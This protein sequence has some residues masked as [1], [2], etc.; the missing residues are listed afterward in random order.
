MA[1]LLLLQELLSD[2]ADPEPRTLVLVGVTGDGKSST[3]NT[4]CGRAAFATSDGLSSETAEPVPADYALSGEEPGAAAATRGL[5][6]V[7]DTVG[8]ADTSLPA[9][10]VAARFAP[11]LPGSGLTSDGAGRGGSTDGL[12]LGFGSELGL[13]AQAASTESAESEAAPNSVLARVTGTSPSA[14]R[15]CA[16]TSGTA[17]ASRRTPAP[18]P[19]RR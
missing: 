8:L 10:E 5:W 3:G 7:I 12:A 2:G 13:D 4:L 1:E 18:A 15:R 14:R 16:C 11:A 17:R 19:R 6:R 9:S